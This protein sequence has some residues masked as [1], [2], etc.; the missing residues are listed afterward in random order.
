LTIIADNNSILMTNHK[1]FY[2]K[3]NAQY[4]VAVVGRYP[5]VEDLSIVGVFDNL[6]FAEEVARR[7]T[8]LYGGADNQSRFV[9]RELPAMNVINLA[10]E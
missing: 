9:I 5:I 6:E 2:S 7:C 8:K 10:Y 1:G 3:E 4:L